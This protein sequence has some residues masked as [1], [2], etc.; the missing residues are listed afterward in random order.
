MEIDRRRTALKSGKRGLLEG[1]PNGRNV[2]ETRYGAVDVLFFFKQRRWIFVSVLTQSDTCQ[3]MVA[4]KLSPFTL[5]VAYKIGKDGL[6]R[7]QVRS[8]YM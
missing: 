3:N 7:N 6:K 8:R 1:K 5:N 2:S 4:K